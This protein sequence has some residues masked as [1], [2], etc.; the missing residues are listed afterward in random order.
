MH[1]FL[2]VEPYMFCGDRGEN[3]NTCEEFKEGRHSIVA[4]S[5][6]ETYGRGIAFSPVTVN[7]SIVSKG[8]SVVS[9]LVQ[10]PNLQADDPQPKD[11]SHGK[12]CFSSSNMVDVEGKGLVSIDSLQIGDYVRAGQ[13]KYSRVYSFSH[14]DHNLEGDYLQIHAKGLDMPVEI[15]PEHMVF[16][17][18]TAIRAS[19]V[20]VGDMFGENT[21]VKIVPVK[22]RGAYAPV[23]E[24]GGL[25]VSGVL[26][27][28]Y[29]AL[30]DYSLVNQHIA[31]HAVMAPHRLVCSFRFELCE[32]ET[33]TNGLSNWIYSTIRIVR[34]FNKLSSFIQIV[35]MLLATPIMAVLYLLEQLILSSTYLFFTLGIVTIL[36]KKRMNQS[37]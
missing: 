16:V 32:N 20:Q 19:E 21:V 28:S 31:A 18:G 8:K 26:A 30:L 2:E 4:Q 36:S 6:S 12:N 22:R 10:P 1:S 25:V 33:Y 3:L 37:K 29:V 15:S 11:E 23:T 17:R 13:N 34:L 35:V 7:F 27:S 24:S 14:L 5:Y 9:Q